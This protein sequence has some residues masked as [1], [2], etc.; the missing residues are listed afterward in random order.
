MPRADWRALGVG[1]E[2]NDHIMSRSTSRSLRVVRASPYG[3]SA[4]PSAARTLCIVAVVAACCSPTVRNLDSRS[5]AEVKDEVTYV[6][7]LAVQRVMASFRMP[8]DHFVSL[9]PLPVRVRSAL[10]SSGS[11]LT[12]AGVSVRRLCRATVSWPG[13]S[14]KVVLWGRAAQGSN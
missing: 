6:V 11:L 8:Y 7:E 10:G 13:G 14:V 4:T 3:P 1:A 2:S 9:R 5:Y 12:P